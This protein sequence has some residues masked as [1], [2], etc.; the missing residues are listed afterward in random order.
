MGHQGPWCECTSDLNAENIG[1]QRLE[2][3]NYGWTID[4]DGGSASNGS[5]T[6]SD[7]SFPPQCGEYDP[8]AFGS[9]AVDEEDPEG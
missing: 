4:Y 2:G 9:G 5:V 1:C 8:D 6:I 3:S 7:L